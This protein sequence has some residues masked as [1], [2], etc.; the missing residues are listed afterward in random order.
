M[1]VR[2]IGFKDVI[3][4]ALNGLANELQGPIGVPSLNLRADWG[5]SQPASSGHPGPPSIKTAERPPSRQIVQRN[6]HDKYVVTAPP[7][8]QGA[9]CP[10]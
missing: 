7:F 9:I 10:F 1:S 4:E 5:H 2:K 8:E 6:G 3:S